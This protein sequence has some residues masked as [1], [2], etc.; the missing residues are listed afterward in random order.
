MVLFGQTGLPRGSHPSFAPSGFGIGKTY[1]GTRFPWG[2]PL[3]LHKSWSEE[4]V[5]AGARPCV[6][7]HPSVLYFPSILCY[8]EGS[9]PCGFV[10]RSIPGAPYD[11]NNIICSNPESVPNSSRVPLPC[12]AP[13]TQ[14]LHQ[15]LGNVNSSKD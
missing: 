3:K 11:S 14:S 5:V 6:H 2:K 7:F 8:R 13:K 9:F 10:S 4:N 12:K 15:K 1:L